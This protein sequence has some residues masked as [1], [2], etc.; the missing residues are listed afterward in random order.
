MNRLIWGT[1][2]IFSEKQVMILWRPVSSI[3]CP[4]KNR[5]SKIWA[6]KRNHSNRNRKIYDKENTDIQLMFQAP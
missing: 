2:N 3:H 5:E 4:L 1:L 6:E